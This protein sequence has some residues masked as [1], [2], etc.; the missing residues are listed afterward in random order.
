MIAAAATCNPISCNPFREN[1]PA[2]FA[3]DLT[4]AQFF[5]ARMVFRNSCPAYV[6][7]DIEV[8]NS[9][10]RSGRMVRAFIYPASRSFRHVYWTS[11]SEYPETSGFPISSFIR[12]SS[13]NEKLSIASMVARTQSGF[14]FI[15]SS[16]PFSVSILPR[17]G[18]R[19][20]KERAKHIEG[21]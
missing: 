20:K 16:P 13:P 11:S 9:G 3:V 4:F 10:E 17:D 7:S 21:R 19:G 1:T 6:R 5:S 15:I 14:N 18:E 2:A 8:T 12:H